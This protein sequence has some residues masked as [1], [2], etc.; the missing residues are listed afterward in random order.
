[1]TVT[2]S[3]H[4]FYDWVFDN[5]IMQV[6]STA[7]VSMTHFRQDRQPSAGDNLECLLHKT[8]LKEIKVYLDTYSS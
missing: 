3:A 4:S 8:C 1:M 6:D 7:N 5:H 2:H